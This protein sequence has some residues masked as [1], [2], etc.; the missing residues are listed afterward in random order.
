VTNADF[1]ELFKL[2][3]AEY[4]IFYAS[5]FRKYIKSY[6]AACYLFGLGEVVPKTTFELFY[7]SIVMIISAIFNANIVGTMAVLVSQLSEK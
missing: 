4:E 2:P 5:I 6:F 3:P 1:I 7:A